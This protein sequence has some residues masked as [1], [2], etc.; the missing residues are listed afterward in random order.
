MKA[1]ILAAGEAKTHR[2]YYFPPDSKPKCLYQVG[3]KT[4]L[5][6]A[7]TSIR[8]A[9]IDDIRIVV[10][11]HSEDIEAYNVENHLGLEVVFNPDWAKSAPSSLFTGL[12][13]VDDDV[14]IVLGDI[15]FSADVIRD[16]LKCTE[17]LAW[18]KMGKPYPLRN[19]P[20]C[21]D[22][23]IDIVKIAKEKFGIFEGINTST[24]IKKFRWKPI[25]SNH[26]GTL[27]Y[28]AFR[29]NGPKGEVLIKERLPEVDYYH[30]T[31][32]WKQARIS[33][34]AEKASSTVG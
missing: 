29:V 19:Y 1:V 20:E 26:L 8:D 9:G 23:S 27:L 18:M 7:V 24:M 34:K 15:M 2:R 5:D 21:I 25:Q 10:G 12:K 22:M 32:E 3:G 13:D 31:D 14:L 30:E 28:E 6:M 4:L 16:F 17:P 11:Y 33:D